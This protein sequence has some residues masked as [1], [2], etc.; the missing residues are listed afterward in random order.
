MWGVGCVLW[1]MLTLRRPFAAETLSEL[2]ACVCKGEYEEQQL[3]NAP[4]APALKRLATR[5]CLLH[6]DPQ[7]RMTLRALVEAL[8]AIEATAPAAVQGP[9][10]AADAAGIWTCGSV[11]ATGAPAHSN[12][13][14]D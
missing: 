12:S 3:A 11:L 7:Q 2:L 4:H 5:E 10:A 8:D 14:V 1:E 9:Q 6:P 13:K